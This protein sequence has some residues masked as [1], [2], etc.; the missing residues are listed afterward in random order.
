MLAVDA[1]GSAD[2]DGV[3]KAYAWNFGDGTTAAGPTASHTYATGGTFHVTL[4]V[5]DD[6]GATGATGQDVTVVAPP[7]SVVVAK[8]AFG[9]TVTGGLGTADLGGAWTASAGAVRQSVDAGVATL[10]LDAA[11]QNTGSY[12]GGVSLTDATVQTS[13]A[14]DAMPTGGGTMVF[15][16]GRRVGTNQE[17]RVRVRF[18]PD[19]Q[20][21]LMLSRLSG[22][23]E[24]YPGG[25]VMVPGLTYTAGTTM[26]VR[27]QVSGTGTTQ[28][29]ASAWPAGSAEPATPT[30]VR[31]DATAELQVPGSVGL[32]VHRPSSATA[33]NVARFAGFTVSTMTAA[34]VGPPPP[35]NV[36]PTASFTA[37]PTGL[38]V[39]LDG[40]GSSDSDG[41]VAGYAW[42]FGD[43]ATAEGMTA[44]HTYASSGTY[45][46]TLTVT[47][48][49]GATAT[50]STD[51]TVLAPPVVEVVASDTFNRSVTGGL[52]TADIGGD[53]TVVAGATRQSVT[54]GVAELRLDAAG[55]N[56]GSYLGGVS[57]TDVDVRATFSLTEMPTGNGT[58]VYVTGRRVGTGQEYRARVRVQ[59]DGRIALAVSR[60]SGGTEAFPGGEVVLPGL[61][62]TAGSAVNVRVTVSGTGTTTV[63]ATVWPAGSAQPAAPSIT[64]TDTTAELQGA[65]TVGLAVHRPSGT[66]VATAVRFTGFTVTPAA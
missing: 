34:P 9:R 12:L 14:L 2:S 24:G 4:T 10:R 47:D 60:L 43:G 37:S 20:V 63:A 21:G 49:D 51:V 41:T 65:G 15:V 40:A 6:K 22:G 27:V 66:T 19:G 42:T 44:S 54:P 32:T 62:Y 48:D 45:P 55:N 35:A 18:A 23:T 33:A 58:Y 36:A 46:V 64:R 8:D 13:F 30:L 1:V 11:N 7:V 26:N 17:Y 38:S 39:S 61:T 16:T 52:G 50:T 57:R 3:V 56:T 59:A 5:I 31:T 25:E 53:W 29:T 28:V